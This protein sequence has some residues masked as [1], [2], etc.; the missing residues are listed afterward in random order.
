MTR[1]EV[2]FTGKDVF[3]EHIRT[4][5]QNDLSITVQSVRTADVYTTDLPEKDAKKG[6]LG[7]LKG[8]NA[9]KTAISLI[10]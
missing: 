1:I 7:I 2:G 3:G 8:I 5:I 6:S 10:S 4:A 9:L